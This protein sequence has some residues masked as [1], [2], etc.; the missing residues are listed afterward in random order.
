MLA[1]MGQHMAFLYQ[2][3]M[4][5]QV[6]EGI[7]VSSGQFNQ[8]FL[9]KEN[10]PLPI[11]QENRIAVAAAQAAQ[12][13]MGSMPPSP[14]QQQMQM[15]MQ[16]KMA[17]LQMKKE[18]LNIR[19]ARFEEGVKTNE[20]QQARKDAEVKAKIVEAASRIAKRDK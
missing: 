17:N 6:Q 3:Q 14:E 4:Q 15:D 2:Q 11:E 9:D 1:H 8:E 5:A 19:K 20:R 12:S 16:E 18:E 7:P 10:K 13:L